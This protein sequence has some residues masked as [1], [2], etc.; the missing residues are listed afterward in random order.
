MST[1]PGYYHHPDEPE[2]GVRH[3]DYFEDGVPEGWEPSVECSYCGGTMPDNTA[4]L[5]AE[6]ERVAQFHARL[7]RERLTQEE[8]VR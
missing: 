8:G 3:T 1:A 6:C 5:H 2:L 7:E 4:R